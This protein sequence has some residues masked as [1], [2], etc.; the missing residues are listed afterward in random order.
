MK[1][2]LSLAGYTQSYI[3]I[4]FTNKKG[5]KG[6]YD[7]LIKEK[8]EPTTSLYKWLERGFIFNNKDLNK[9]FELLYKTR[10]E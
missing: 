4:F 5:C 2:K 8:R 9:I 10:E 7:E 6:K 3:K 1:S